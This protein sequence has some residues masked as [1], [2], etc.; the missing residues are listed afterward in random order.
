MLNSNILYVGPRCMK[1]VQYF[2]GNEKSFKPFFNDTDLNL[3]GKPTCS[4]VCK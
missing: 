3:I 4:S 1:L 2:T